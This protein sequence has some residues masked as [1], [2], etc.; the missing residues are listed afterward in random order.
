[1]FIYP[2]RRRDS[3]RVVGKPEVICFPAVV[4][5]QHL[6]ACQAGNVSGIRRRQSTRFLVDASRMV[7]LAR[8][9][10]GIRMGRD[11]EGFRV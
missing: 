7:L 3:G 6:P 2:S 1:M 5:D 10:L 4:G 9:H 8:C 11:E